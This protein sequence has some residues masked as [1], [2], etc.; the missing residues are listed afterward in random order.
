M[1]NK[2]QFIKFIIIAL[3]IL[4][5]ILML[6]YWLFYKLFGGYIATFVQKKLLKSQL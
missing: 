6:P 2:H 4:I 3:C 5:V 1:E